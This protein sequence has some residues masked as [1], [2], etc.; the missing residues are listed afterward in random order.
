MQT[1]SLKIKETSINVTIKEH[2][3][4]RHNFEMAWALW[5]AK[6][7]EIEIEEQSANNIIDTKLSA[8]NIRVIEADCSHMLTLAHSW[9]DKKVLA[10]ML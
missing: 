9:L 2:C 1:P 10:G 8:A 7:F 5:I 6:T 4:V 3:P